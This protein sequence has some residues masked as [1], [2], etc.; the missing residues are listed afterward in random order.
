VDHARPLNPSTREPLVCEECWETIF[1][2]GQQKIL[3]ENNPAVGETP[4]WLSE[5]ARVRPAPNQRTRNFTFMVIVMSLLVV[6]ML[7]MTVMI[8][9]LK[10]H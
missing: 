4:D 5:T 3:R 7:G 1:Q 6:L 2:Y 8:A 9:L 10:I